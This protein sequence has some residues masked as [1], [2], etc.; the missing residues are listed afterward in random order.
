MPLK[1]NFKLFNNFLGDG[2]RIAKNVKSSRTDFKTLY[3][4][5]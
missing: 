3:C 4:F 5:K 2:K 1:A